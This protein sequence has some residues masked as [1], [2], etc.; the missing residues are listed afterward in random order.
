MKIR[1]L[2]LEEVELSIDKLSSKENDDE[3]DNLYEDTK[4]R[5]END[6]EDTSDS[7][8]EEDTDLEDEAS[9]A[10]PADVEEAETESKD[11]D[12]NSPEEISA[13]SIHLVHNQIHDIFISTESEFGDKVT[14][15][16]GKVASKTWD[17]TKEYGPVVLRNVYEG[18]KKALQRIYVALNEVSKKLY[19]YAKKKYHS[20][21]N[22]IDRINKVKMSL[23][24][25]AD[26]GYSIP[27]DA[28]FDKDVVLGKLVIGES[29]DFIHNLEILSHFNEVYDNDL[30]QSVA[31]QIRGIK[32]TIEGVLTTNGK[33]TTNFDTKP[34]IT[35][36][37]YGNVRG[38]E[39]DSSHLCSYYYSQMLPGSVSFIGHVPKPN[40]EINDLKEALN[41]SSYF[42]GYNEAGRN[43][44]S[45]EYLDL[46]DLQKLLDVAVKIC[47][48]G[49]SFEKTFTDIAKARMSLIKDFHQYLDY[50]EKSKDQISIKDSLVEL[51]SAR[52]AFMD[53]TSIA[54]AMHLHDFNI[55]VISAALS[56]AKSTISTLKKAN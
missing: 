30:K 36:F 42:L 50:L 3:Y 55:R 35:G 22:Y 14:E 49:L 32:N 37:K 18:I 26:S 52:L 19:K 28:R 45:I 5:I 7:D 27:K 2:G 34:K 31:S 10:D 47:E 44:D 29:V 25:L 33:T 8:T 54:G 9:E 40:L 11:I 39:P 15:G 43:L 38:F 4:T 6:K 51:L 1:G 12:E 16:L 20:Y 56:L 21:Q 23:E 46:D 13:E 24:E 53:K 17:L 41:L 48:N